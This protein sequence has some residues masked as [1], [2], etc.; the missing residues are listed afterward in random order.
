LESR[1][2]KPET[3]EAFGVG[4]APDEW[5]FLLDAGRA[6]GYDQALVLESGL[7][8]R[9]ERGNVYDLFRNRLMFPIR[10]PSG[11]VIAF[12]GRDLSGTAPGKYINS[13][14]NAVYKKNRTLYGVYEARDAMRKEDRALLCEGY[15]DVFAVPRR[16]PEKRGG[17]VRHGVDPA[18]G[19][20]VAPLR[21]GSGDVV[22]RRRGRD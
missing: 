8:K 14:E 1:A 2:L 10:N 11:D 9:N 4:F 18:T 16:G 7:A 15:F 17:D 6:K 5:Q 13:P 20:V 3:S 19:R 12:G 22:R 21:A